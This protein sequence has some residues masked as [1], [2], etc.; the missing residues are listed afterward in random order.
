MSMGGSVRLPE[1]G[2]GPDGLSEGPRP[3]AGVLFRCFLIIGLTGFGGV[4]PLVHHELVRRHRWMSET[5]FAE[6]LAICQVLPGPNVLNVAVV[7]GTRMAGWRGGA[8]CLAG[9]LAMPLVVV[10]GL[11]TLYGEFARDPRVMPVM[12]AVAAAAAGLVV[13]LALRLL[14]PMRGRAR[15]LVLAGLACSGVAGL[16]LPLVAVLGVLAPLSVWLAWREL[17][18]E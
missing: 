12:G 11:A 17:G 5:G 18:D 1:H 4:L 10:L 14:W 2:V 6:A 7:F 8:A 15:D 3:A 16:G 13:A 9:L